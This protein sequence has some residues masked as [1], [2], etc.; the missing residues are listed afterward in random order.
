MIRST[1]PEE[2]PSIAERCAAEQALGFA[3]LVRRHGPWTLAWLETI[4]RVADWRVS[5]EETGEAA[6]G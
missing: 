6:N 1:D 4:L 2:L 5:A 3:Y